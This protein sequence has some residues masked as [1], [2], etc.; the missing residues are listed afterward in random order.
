M[1]EDNRL[2]KER[3]KTTSSEDK[4]KTIE[5]MAEMNKRLQEVNINCQKQI[6]EYG[7]L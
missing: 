7:K 1:I 5:M 4:S 3:L 6:L 2:L